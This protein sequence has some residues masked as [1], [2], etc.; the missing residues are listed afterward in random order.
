MEEVKGRKRRVRKLGMV[1]AMMRARRERRRVVRGF[2]LRGRFGCWMELIGFI[3]G[4]EMFICTV[5]LDLDC[6][7]DVNS[8]DEG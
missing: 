5:G 1:E 4:L 8:K 7:V 2:S 6:L 3:E